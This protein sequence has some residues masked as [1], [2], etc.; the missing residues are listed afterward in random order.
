MCQNDACISNSKVFKL[1]AK[2]F[3]VKFITADSSELLTKWKDLSIKLLLRKPQG[4]STFIIQSGPSSI[5]LISFIFGL[6]GHLL[7]LAVPIDLSSELHAV[8]IQ[9][10]LYK[11]MYLL[12]IYFLFGK[13]FAKDHFWPLY[14]PSYGTLY[15]YNILVTYQQ[16]FRYII[17]N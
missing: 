1:N 15:W 6:H 5:Y 17:V 8:I 7:P 12:N 3:N 13:Y 10:S 4:W 9:F 16:Y 11:Y 14:L 2:D